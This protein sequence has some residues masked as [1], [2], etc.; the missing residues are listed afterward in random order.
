MIKV[1]VIVPVYNI[2]N[3]IEHCAR[4][5]FNQTLKDIE[6]IFV[7]D[8][9]PDRSMEILTGV[10]NEYPEL[11][12]Y[13]RV[14][15]HPQ[16]LG[17]PSARNSGMAIARGEYLIHCDGDD[18]V[19]QD[20]YEKMYLKAKEEDAEIVGC[21]FYYEFHDRRE[22]CAQEFDLCWEDCCRNVLISQAMMPNIWCRLVKR[23]LY[24]DHNLL[25][26]PGINM[27]EDL[28]TSMKLH[29]FARK[30]TS[31]H[32]ALYHYVQYNSN[33]IVHQLNSRQI[34]E[35]EKACHVI[36]DFLKQENLLNKFRPEFLERVFYLKKDSLLNKSVR[37]Y[38]YW[39]SF[40]PESNHKVWHYHLRWD[41]KLMYWFAVIGIPGLTVCIIGLKKKLKKLVSR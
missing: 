27:C 31:V 17:L 1:S 41:V 32:E 23:S 16:N 6:F 19:E 22:Y 39:K 40:Y 7:D 26:V 3:Y 29:V 35:I 36:E 13:I 30:T 11:K 10:I 2:E 14:V 8:C 34:K 5:L 37:N 25:F 4:S 20:I 33:S 24:V 28:I 38:K 12:E 9:T 18:W 15:H 21:D